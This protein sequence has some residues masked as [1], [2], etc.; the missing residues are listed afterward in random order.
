MK[1]NYFQKGILKIIIKVK[2][3]QKIFKD[4]IYSQIIQ[5]KKKIRNKWIV[6]NN[7][8]KAQQDYILLVKIKLMI[9]YQKK[10]IN[11]LIKKE[12]EKKYFYQRKQQTKINYVKNIILEENQKKIRI[13]GNI[14][15][16]QKIIL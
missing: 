8:L 11:Y 10:K 14:I 7:L 6:S 1:D 16:H 5:L 9:Q 12:K 4:L 15:V 3:T 13:Q 2:L